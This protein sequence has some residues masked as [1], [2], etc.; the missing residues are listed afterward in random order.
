[1]NY[2]NYSAF[3][4]PPIKDAAG[5]VFLTLV[6]IGTVVCNGPDRAKTFEKQVA[7]LR[8]ARRV[9]QQ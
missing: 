2:I 3:V 9:G 8:S 6:L 4:L 1:V 5:N 7:D